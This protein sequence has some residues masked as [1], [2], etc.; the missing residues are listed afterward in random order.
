MSSSAVE[1]VKDDGVA[2]P[3]HDD[4]VAEPHESYSSSSSRNVAA[5]AAGSLSGDH[6]FAA[7]PP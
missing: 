2:Q 6:S 7:K 5:K 1:Q 3:I 4:M